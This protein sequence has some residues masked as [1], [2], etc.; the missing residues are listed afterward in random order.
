VRVGD[1][2]SRPPVKCLQ[3][4]ARPTE[5][6]IESGK[7][8][9]QRVAPISKETLSLLA[10]EHLVLPTHVVV[11]L[12][13]EFSE[14]C[15]ARIK[16]GELF[17]DDDGRPHVESNMVGR[18]DEIVCAL[19][20]EEG[21]AKDGAPLEIERPVQLFDKSAA[22]RGGVESSR[23]VDEECDFHFLRDAPDGNAVPLG[24]RAAQR[25]VSIDY[26]L[27]GRSQR[28]DVEGRVDPERD[29]NIVGAARA[30]HLMHEPQGLL[31]IGEWMLSHLLPSVIRHATGATCIYFKPAAATTPPT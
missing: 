25:S 26:R 15:T 1:E 31:A 17:E 14:C 23:I 22:Q 12:E 8:A 21:D 10:A 29:M 28:V 9:A 2:P 27:E 4:G 30:I 11:V 20:A 3:R 18:D 5:R 7:V 6:Q 24:K 13:G 16:R 19:C